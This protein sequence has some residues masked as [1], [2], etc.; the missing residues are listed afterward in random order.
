MGDEAGQ[1]HERH[2]AADIDAVL[3]RIRS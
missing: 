2:S 3:A 1:L